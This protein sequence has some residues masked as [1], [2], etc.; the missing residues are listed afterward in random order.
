[1]PFFT[2]E[3]QN[4]LRFINFGVKALLCLAFGSGLYT[5]Q[6]QTPIVAESP[7]YQNLQ[8][9]KVSFNFTLLD[10]EIPTQAIEGNWQVY[11]AGTFQPIDSLTR[12]QQSQAS[13]QLA[14]QSVYDLKITAPKHLD[15]TLRINLNSITE[16]N[17]DIIISLKPD[18]L[19]L[20]ISIIDLNTDEALPL[21][22]IVHNRTRPE[23][24]LLSPEYQNQGKYRIGVREEDEYEMEIRNNEGYIFYTNQRIIPQRNKENYLEVQVVKELKPNTKIRLHNVNFGYNQADLNQYAQEELIRIVPLLKSYPNLLIEIAAHT[25]N[26]GTKEGNLTLSQKRADVVKSFLV[27]QGIASA[28]IITQALGEKQPIASNQ[29]E[30]GRKQNRRFELRVL[31]IE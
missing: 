22:G 20:D 15:T 29:T 12:F 11:L 8:V 6:A 21:G 27:A 13:F 4:N 24:I 17:L 18:K 26:I 31:R 25:D 14:I 9:N 3:K 16:Y 2:S 28:Q 19:D 1:M 10:A 5:I 7:V 30:E 23:S